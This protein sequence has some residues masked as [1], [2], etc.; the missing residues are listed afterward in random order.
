TPGFRLG[1]PV[2]PTLAS[3]LTLSPPLLTFTG[4][5][6]ALSIGSLSNGTSVFSTTASCST[7]PEFFTTKVTSPAGTLDG[8]AV[9]PIGAFP[10]ESVKLTCTVAAGLAP[11]AAAVGILT[12][13]SSVAARRELVVVLTQ[14]ASATQAAPTTRC[15][16]MRRRGR[17]AMRRLR[18]LRRVQC[19]G[20]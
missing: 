9:R 17:P 7:V 11:S 10:L 6:P 14:P 8:D 15:L 16:T 5:S 1:S 18:G 19:V 4:G 2:S 20:P 3:S 12:P 13:P